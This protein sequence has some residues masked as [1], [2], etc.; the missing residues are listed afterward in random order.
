MINKNKKIKN[1][2]ILGISLDI[3]LKLITRKGVSTF[4]IRKLTFVS[5]YAFLCKCVSVLYH[6]SQ[7]GKKTFIFISHNSKSNK[8]N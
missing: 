7:P 6:V 8:T 2:G 1:L 3:V 5:E 4:Y